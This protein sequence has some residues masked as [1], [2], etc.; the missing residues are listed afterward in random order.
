MTVQLSTTARNNRLDSIESTI[1]ASPTLELRSGA[2]PANC[3]AADT[4]TLIASMALPADFMNAAAGGSKTLNGTWQ[5]ASADSSG[6]VGHFR[7]KQGGT[8]HVQGTVTNT[9]GGG[10][11]TLDNVVLNSGQQVTIT[12]FTLNEGNA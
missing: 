4:G 6:T 11:M 10:D 7:I 1:G 3:A 12:T 9:G 5:D 2:P 8:T